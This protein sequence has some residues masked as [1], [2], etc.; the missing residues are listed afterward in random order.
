MRILPILMGEMKVRFAG[1]PFVGWQGQKN[2]YS[3]NTLPLLFELEHL[4]GIMESDKKRML[5]I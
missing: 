3:N 1:Y 2:A 5:Y 4:F